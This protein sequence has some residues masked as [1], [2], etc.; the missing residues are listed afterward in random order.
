MRVLDEGVL[1]A[2]VEDEEVPGA[3]EQEAAGPTHLGQT[4][5]LQELP[6]GTED[7]QA[8]IL[9]V[10]HHHPPLGVHDQACRVVQAART[11]AG[12]PEFLLQ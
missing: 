2:E 1:A 9:T 4:R 8:V 12:L 11:R 3:G 6:R 10:G 5:R 7:A